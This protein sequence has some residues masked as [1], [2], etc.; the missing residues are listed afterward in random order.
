MK[1]ISNVVLYKS[2]Y[3]KTLAEIITSAYERHVK[4]FSLVDFYTNSIGMEKRH[5]I[6]K[7][8]FSAFQMHFYPKALFFFNAFRLFCFIMSEYCAIVLCAVHMW[9]KCGEGVNFF[10]S[11]LKKPI[12]IPVHINNSCNLIKEY[13]C[14]SL[15][16]VPLYIPVFYCTRNSLQRKR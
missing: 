12:F 10:H 7:S 13:F 3:N 5:C 11:R 15:H 1:D 6:I 8:P 2:H 9:F 14:E 4:T 16:V